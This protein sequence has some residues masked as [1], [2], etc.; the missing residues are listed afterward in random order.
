MIVKRRRL[1]NQRMCVFLLGGGGI[2]RNVNQLSFN[3][4]WIVRCGKSDDVEMM[5]FTCVY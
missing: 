2:K 3:D 4:N 5:N 1:F